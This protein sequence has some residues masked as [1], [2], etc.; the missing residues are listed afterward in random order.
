M[1]NWKTKTESIRTGQGLKYLLFDAAD[2]PL[3]FRDFLELI[4]RENGF[5]TYFIELLQSIP[6]EAY[7]WET[8]PVR[9]ID[10]DRPF[11]FVVINSKHLHGISPDKIAFSDYYDNPSDFKGTVS[12][13]NLRGDAKLIVPCPLVEDEAYPHLAAFM[14]NAP[15]EQLDAFWQCVGKTM[16][17]HV[18]EKHTWLSTAGLGVSWLHIRLDS[19]P[20]YYKYSPYKTAFYN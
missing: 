11:E 15:L 20:K 14:K 12:F 6:F 3:L 7:F 18:S 17:E 1:D 13:L 8:P 2:K 16:S 5:R 4:Q 10:L 9:N 19:R